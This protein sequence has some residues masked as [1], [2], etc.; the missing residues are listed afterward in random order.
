MPTRCPRPLSGTCAVLA[1]AFLA[2]AGP[3]RAQV[4]WSEAPSTLR[5]YPR[6]EGSDSG[7]VRIAG[8]A[9]GTA[10]GFTSIRARVLREGRLVTTAQQT[11]N[12]LDGVARFDLSVAIR[13]E[14][15]QH[16]IEVQGMVGDAA[17]LLLA[18]DSVVA[19]EVVVIQ[20]QSNA[21]AC[22]RG[23]E[24]A[25]SLQSP[26]IRVFGNGSESFPLDGKWR[27]GDG[28][29]CSQGDG[30]TGQWGLRFARDVVDSSGMPVAIF[31]GAKGASGIGFFRWNP[32]DHD[33]SA[34]NYGRMLL[35]LTRSG[36]LGGVRTLVWYQGEQNAKEGMSTSAYRSA[37]LDL[38]SQWTSDIPSLKRFYVFQIRNGCQASLS[39]S[40][41][42]QEAQRSLV[43]LPE[44]RVLST[45]A[46]V[47]VAD[48]CHFGFRGGY[49]VAGRN[50]YRLFARDVLS[51][52]SLD[53]VESPLVRHAVRTGS[54][55]IT[56]RLAN[57]FDS[58][59]W[60]AGSEGLLSLAGGGG[61]VAAATTGTARVFLATSAPLSAS[62]TIGVRG[63]FP[64]PD[65]VVVNRN[66]TGL[67]HFQGMATV[68]PRQMDSLVILALLRLNGSS[69]TVGQ[70]ATFGNEGR[71]T[72]LSLRSLSLAS[73][74]PDLFLL[75]S[76]VS[77]DVRDNRL[78]SLPREILALAP[79]ARIQVEGNRLCS[80]DVARRS[81]VDA[82][83]EAADW[84]A[85]QQC[86][87]TSIAGRPDPGGREVVRLVRGATGYRVVFP[88][89]RPDR[90]IDL[91]RPDGHLVISLPAPGTT[92]ELPVAARPASLAILRVRD[93]QG[94]QAA[95]L[96]PPAGTPA[97]R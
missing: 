97:S 71:L 41:A 52:T 1:A 73:M 8:S 34:T 6:N 51:R 64:E 7:T 96:V 29:V 44:V 68:T 9:T 88:K 28:D 24:F 78:T 92:L 76:L 47:Q 40:E 65:P 63:R 30:G 20:G 33:D 45:S 13:A 19:G 90:R 16:R 95:I 22:K 31:N 69:A 72:R 3:A 79:K 14:L 10:A 91:L 74:S 37:F 35:R 46:Q 2:G 75:D 70:V 23:A 39:A 4:T 59:R 77:L 84:F 18:A 80:L 50:L 93:L 87:S 43:D 81:W 38:K 86:A 54:Q 17:T 53:D 11:L 55:E 66:G 36:V 42:I 58:I 25:N 82:R 32:S 60:V 5:L 48:S 62:T 26:F 15:A 21:E 49:E 83:S 85:A 61:S 56:L 12:V 89:E 94:T 67:V 57:P 27:R